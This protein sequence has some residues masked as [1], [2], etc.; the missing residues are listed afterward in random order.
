MRL[1]LI[2]VPGGI[3]AKVVAVDASGDML[4]QFGSEIEVDGEYVATTDPD[5][6]I[7]RYIRPAASI[8]RN[9]MCAHLGIEDPITAA[10]R[11]TR[12]FLATQKKD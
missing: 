12:E 3:P 10:I 11:E 5:D 8:L 6:V 9:Q 4:P 1:F 2:A 7:A